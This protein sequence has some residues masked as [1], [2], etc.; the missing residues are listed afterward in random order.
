MEAMKQEAGGDN[1]GRA[2]LL[3][4]AGAAV[5]PGLAAWLAA[6]NGWKR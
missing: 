2:G 1:R 6:L 3:K 5:A 4:T